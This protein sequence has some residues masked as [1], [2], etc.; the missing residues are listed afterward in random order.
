MQGEN[1]GLEHTQDKGAGSH[2]QAAAPL[3]FALIALLMA[4]IGISIME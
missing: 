1:F 2:K 4:C 3:V